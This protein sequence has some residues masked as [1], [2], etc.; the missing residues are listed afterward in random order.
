[1]GRSDIVLSG[2]IFRGFLLGAVGLALAL[3]AVGAGASGAEHLQLPTPDGFRIIKQDKKGV[4]MLPT[5]ES[6]D[7]WTR[8]VTTQIFGGYVSSKFYPDYRAYIEKLSKEQCAD[9]PTTTIQEGE[10]EGLQNHVWI[11]KCIPK[12]EATPPD[13]SFLRFIQGNDGAYIVIAE[14]K[15]KPSDSQLK[16]VTDILES[17]KVVTDA[18]P[19][20]DNP[21]AVKDAPEKPAADTPT[22]SGL[23]GENLLQGLPAGFKIANHGR[24]ATG[25]ELT[26]MVPQNETVDNWTQMVTTQVYLGVTD[27][28]DAYKAEMAKRFKDNCQ[29]ADVQNIRDGEENGYA[30]HVWMQSCHQSDVKAKPEITFFKYIQGKDSSYVVQRAFHL[31]PSRDQVTEAVKYLQ[32]I[33]VCDSRSKESPCPATE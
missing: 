13:Y 32:Q 24:S 2:R 7:K 18:K 26:E 23:T 16:N 30:F 33:R 1:M 29:Q 12:N 17:A 27:Y 9:A 25:M 8:R 4:E 6:A 14:V 20:V 19:A 31:E 21:Y 28:F 11:Q 22:E 15:F 5:G 3:P 10:I